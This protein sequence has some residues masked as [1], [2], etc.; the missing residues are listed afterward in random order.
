MDPV[1]LFLE[2]FK[3]CWCRGSGIST[4]RQVAAIATTILKLILNPSFDLILV[5]YDIQLLLS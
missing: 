4:D 2:Y 3:A 5:S 1:L